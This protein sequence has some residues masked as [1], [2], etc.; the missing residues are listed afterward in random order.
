MNSSTPSPRSTDDAAALDLLTSRL[1]AIFDGLITDAE[2]AE[3]ID[4]Y[5]GANQ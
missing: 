3:M 5:A 2:F 4:M 1:H